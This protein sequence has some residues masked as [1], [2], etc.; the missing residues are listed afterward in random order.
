MKRL[1][2]QAKNTKLLR[3][4]AA[5]CLLF[6]LSVMSEAQYAYNG[7]K[8][9]LSK[10]LGEKWEIVGL[11]NGGRG[12]GKQDYTSCGLNLGASYKISKDA[13]LY[14]FAKGQ[15]ADYMHVSNRDME[16]SIKE[17]ISWRRTSG[18]FFGFYFEQKRLFYKPYDYAQNV[19][20]FCG[21]A[22]YEHT[23]ES[24]GIHG[25]ASGQAILNMT[26][27]NTKASFIQRAKVN[28]SAHKRIT[29]K[30]SM[31]L[32]Y[33]YGHW[34]DRQIYIADRDNLHNFGVCITYCLG[35]QGD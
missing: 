28:I 23:W 31:G 3:L 27:P 11:A 35:G 20:C 18:F 21:F 1:T 17:M 2:S 24:T 26:S 29:N 22:G 30:L 6:M 19:S 33:T 9:A 16:M 13:R 32:D 15:Y 25:R 12:F 34:G 10:D 4:A 14:V 7:L 5:L 8:I